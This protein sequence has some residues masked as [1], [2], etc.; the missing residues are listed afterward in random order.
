MKS[1]SAMNMNRI[2]YIFLSAAALLC[3]ASCSQELLGEYAQSSDSDNKE[4]HFLQKSL[5]KEFKQGLS[6][7]EFAVTLARNGNK[8]TYKVVLQKSGM[9]ASLFSLR[10]TVVIPDGKYSVDIPVRVDLSKVV[11]G[12]SVTASLAIVGR[13]AELDDNPS[14]ISQ[15]SDFLDLTASFILEWEPYMRTTESGETVQQTATYNYNLFYNGYQSGILVEKAKGTDNVF[16]LL[17][18]AAGTTFTFRIE[19]NKNVVVP[20]QSIGYLYEQSNEYVQVADL[21]QYLGGSGSY[22]SSYPC[23]FDGKNFSLSLIYFVTDGI[24]D[25]GTETFSFTDDH[26]FDASVSV[27]YDGDGKFSFEFGRYTSY[28][29]A[30]VVPGNITNLDERLSEWNKKICMGDETADIR[31][32]TEDKQTWTPAQP[33]NTLLVVPFDEE[34]VPGEMVAIRF[35]YDPSGS[36]SPKI[37]EM[38]L[39]AYDAA[40]YSTLSWTVKTVNAAKVRY[41]VMEKDVLDYF[42]GRYDLSQLL[43]AGSTLSDENLAKANGEEGLT[44]YFQNLKSGGEYRIIV[45]ATNSFGDAETKTASAK[46]A[47]H[48]DKFVSKTID[49][50]VGAYLVNAAVTTSDSDNSTTESY[51]VDIVKSSD[52]MV[53]IKGLSNY[54]LYSPSITGTFIPE[55]NAIRVYP[56]SLGEFSYLRVVFGFVSNL[57]SGIWNP[58]N[59]MEFGFSDNGLLY[60]RTAKTGVTSGSETDNVELTG[61]KFLLFDGESYTNYAV[62]DKTYTDIIMQKL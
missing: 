22:Y 57:Y 26:D 52:N 7:G 17:D 19:N 16:R 11:L 36:Q 48:A 1:E 54:N 44:L 42:E 32:F 13:D 28:C 58:A 33:N 5:T 62:A 20:R 49:D 14:Y 8:G 15:Y 27:T 23:T 9:N 53:S 60:W 40:K 4:I 25:Y 21:D 29:K 12:S 18:W 35:T 56:Q 31:K 39:K 37:E 2:K 24:F 6:T 34:D 30:V 46:L 50:F 3:A 38:E 45:Q 51:R 61:Y 43:D 47:S 55:C 41:V 59:S 10:D